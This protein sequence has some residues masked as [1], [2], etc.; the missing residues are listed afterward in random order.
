MQQRSGC[1]LHYILLAAIL[2]VSMAPLALG[3]VARSNMQLESYVV[4]LCTCPDEHT[5]SALATELV[6]T[7]LAACVNIVPSVRS[8]YHWQGEVVT[9]QESLLMIKT[10][11]SRY[12]ELESAIVQ[13][14]PY[15]V[16][17]ILQLRIAAGSTRYLAWMQTVVDSR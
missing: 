13:H 11:A 3:A 10:T 9:D 8:I 16:P 4:V 14:H 5:A 1:A 15:D 12:A 7:R 6:Q 2:A 17:E